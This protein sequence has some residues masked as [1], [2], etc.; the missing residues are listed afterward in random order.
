MTT[1]KSSSEDVTCYEGQT[2]ILPYFIEAEKS[3]GNAL[4][5]KI[6]DAI[7]RIH[8]PQHF[9]KCPVCKQKCIAGTHE[10]V[11]RKQHRWAWFK[12]D[13]KGWFSR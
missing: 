3:L 5:Q 4:A 6:D 10:R 8:R 11:C 9:K 1:E 13:I 7:N 12:R 2:D